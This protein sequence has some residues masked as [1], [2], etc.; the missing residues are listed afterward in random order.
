[1]NRVLVKRF[2]DYLLELVI[3]QGYLT[4][5]SAWSMNV[6]LFGLWSRL[7]AFCFQMY[8]QLST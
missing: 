2:A 6:K 3:I 1:M 5:S 4:Q 7:R 8:T